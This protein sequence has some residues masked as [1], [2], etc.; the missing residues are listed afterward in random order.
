MI[1]DKSKYSQKDYDILSKINYEIREDNI[2]FSNIIVKK[3]WGYEYLLFENEDVAIWIL[4]IDANHQTSMHCHPNKNTSLICLKGEVVCKTLE[5]EYKFD[6][7]NGIYL[8]RKVYHQ[9]FNQNNTQ[10]IIM[11]IESP[12]N[13]FDL[14]RLNDNYGRSGKSYENRENYKIEN[15][16]TLKNIFEKPFSKIIGELNVEIGFA[17]NKNAFSKIYDESNDKVI[18]TL[19]NRHIWSSSGNKEFEVGQLI[20]LNDE[21]LT[22]YNINN[23]FTYLKISKE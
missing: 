1:I 17:E 2:D 19:L 14:V 10:S 21:I 16:L 12:V 22:K 8:G 20:V 15:G 6:K 18:L 7:L 11:E 13:K 3:P 23:N 5:D 4:H 9:T